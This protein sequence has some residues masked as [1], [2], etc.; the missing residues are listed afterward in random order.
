MAF[1]QAQIK[2]HFL[3]NAFNT[4]SAIALTDGVAASELIDDLGVYLRSSFQAR[5]NGELVPLARELETTEAYLRIQKARFGKRLNVEM[6]ITTTVNY[7][8]PPLI[9]QPLVENAVR[10]GSLGKTGGITVRIHTAIEDEALVISV[11]DDGA[12]MDD[13]QINLLKEVLGEE[14]GGIGLFNVSRRLRLR[15]PACCSSVTTGVPSWTCAATTCATSQASSSPRSGSPTSTSSR[16]R[17]RRRRRFVRPTSTSAS[18]GRGPSPSPSPSATR[19]TGRPTS[20][21]SGRFPGTADG[22]SAGS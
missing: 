11:S 14:R 2:P 4:I 10:H 7:P 5:E 18:C 16:S 19:S 12:G 22:V 1:L 9:L 17:A 21:R 13:R 15:S 3:Y 6:D 20:R 8:V